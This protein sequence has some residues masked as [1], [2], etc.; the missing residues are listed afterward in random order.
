L[1]DQLLGGF[2]QADQRTI[3][4]VRPRSLL[5][6]AAAGG[7]GSTMARE[8]SL[9]KDDSRLI[10]ELTKYGV[11]LVVQAEIATCEAFGDHKGAEKIRKFFRA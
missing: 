10:E 8:L 2:V 11:F 4:I 3:R 1:R 7:A 5:P 9:K 6:L